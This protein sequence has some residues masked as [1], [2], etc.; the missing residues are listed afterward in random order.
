[1]AAQKTEYTKHVFIFNVSATLATYRFTSHLAKVGA[2]FKVPTLFSKL[3]VNL[4]ET[5]IINQ[6]QLKKLED[7]KLPGDSRALAPFP[8]T[9][10][11]IPLRRDGEGAPYSVYS[12]L[13][14]RHLA[15]WW[16]PRRGP[17]QNDTGGTR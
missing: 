16:A 15:S 7:Y 14:A 11:Q 9:N 10:R 2:E 13:V 12:S 6:F 17:P 8:F 5:W 3:G 4:I 1:M